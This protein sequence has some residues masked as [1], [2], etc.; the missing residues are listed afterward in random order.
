MSVPVSISRLVWQW[1]LEPA[2][3]SPSAASCLLRADWRPAL[4]PLRNAWLLKTLWMTYSSSPLSHHEWNKLT[5]YPWQP[6]TVH[7]K[8]LNF[9]F[10]TLKSLLW[11]VTAGL[12]WKTVW[13]T[14]LSTSGFTISRPHILL[15]RSTDEVFFSPHPL[16]H[17]LLLVP[18]LAP[19]FVC[20]CFD[21][22]DIQMEYQTYFHK[23][24]PGFDW[25]KDLSR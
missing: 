24:S 12:L 2:L 23:G 20:Q 21:S 17:P 19:L 14:S 18:S 7:L 13:W 25:A 1:G 16:T 3:P 10:A 9:P 6:L 8:W 15:P 22:C 11:T 4:D 5:L